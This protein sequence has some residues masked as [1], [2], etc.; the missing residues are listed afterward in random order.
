MFSLVIGELVKPLY[1]LT[2]DGAGLTMFLLL[3]LLFL[4][5]AGLLLWNLTIKGE[6]EINVRAI[7]A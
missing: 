3:S 4:V 7:E 6:M 1:H 5:L 2:P